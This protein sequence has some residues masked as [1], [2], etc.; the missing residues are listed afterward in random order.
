MVHAPLSSSPSP[1]LLGF[2]PG[3]SRTLGRIP[4]LTWIDLLSITTASGYKVVPCGELDTYITFPWFFALRLLC[5]LRVIPLR[6]LKQVPGFPLQTYRKPGFYREYPGTPSFFSIAAKMRKISTLDPVVDAVPRYS[7]CHL[8][9]NRLRH[10]LLVSR[11]CF[12]TRSRFCE[13]YYGK[14]LPSLIVTTT[15]VIHVNLARAYR[16][17]YPYADAITACMN[18]Q[19]SIRIKN[20]RVL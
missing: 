9:H 3:S 15:L 14:I 5:M 7:D 16:T 10:G 4:W 12:C 2:V 6:R 20:F 11:L 19:I 13:T 17:L 1:P 18:M 8:Y